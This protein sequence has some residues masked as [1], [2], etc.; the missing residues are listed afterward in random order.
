MSDADV[1]LD[2]EI[3]AKIHNQLKIQS[4]MIDYLE[5]KIHLVIDGL[6]EHIKIC[7]EQSQGFIAQ[8][9][10]LSNCV[11]QHINDRVDHIRHRIDIKSSNSSV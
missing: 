5:T 8:I 6:T 11:E 2:R 10:M 9:N 4:N 1:K 3:L 7:E